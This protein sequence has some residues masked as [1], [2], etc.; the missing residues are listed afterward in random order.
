MQASMVR[1]ATALILSEVAAEEPVVVLQGVGRR[2]E[3]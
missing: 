3:V 1:M 2:E